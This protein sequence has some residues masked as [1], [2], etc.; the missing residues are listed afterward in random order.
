MTIIFDYDG[1]LHNTARL[2]YSAIRGVCDKLAEDGFA[3][4]KELSE[5]QISRYLGM[6]PM[7]MWD[8]FMP[9]LPDEVKERA[10]RMAGELMERNIY[11]DAQLYD[12]ATELLEQ[13]KANGCRLI[14]LSNSYSSYIDA[15]R[16]RFGLDRFFDDYFTAEE[17]GF[18]PKYKIVPIIMGKYP[19]RE[20]ALVGDRSSDLEAAKKNGLPFAACLYGF[21]SELELSGS[22]AEVDLKSGAACE[23]I[24]RAAR[25]FSALSS[26]VDH[27]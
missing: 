6:T 17:Y 20:Y 16:E 7:Q 10:S 22:D 24:I 21:G 2:Y 12:G 3:E 13:L 23:N 19:D 11:H 8:D 27:G 5:R 25:M 26:E 1:T 15:H 9:D 14:I 4:K 18:T